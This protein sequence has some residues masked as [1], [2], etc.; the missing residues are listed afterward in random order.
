MSARAFGFAAV[1]P[2]LVTIQR[3][4]S[5]GGGGGLEVGATA[6]PGGGGAG[7]FK[8]TAIVMPS[9][10]TRSIVIGG[11]GGGIPNGDGTNGGNLTVTGLPSCV[12]GGG[13]GAAGDAGKAGGNGGGGG[14]NG[15]VGPINPGG[16]G[17]DFNGQNGSNG[18]SGGSG[19]GTSASIGTGTTS[20]IS[21]TSMVYGQGGINSSPLA[22]PT[23]GGGGYG[24]FDLGL[25]PVGTDLPGAPG[26][27]GNAV[28]SYAGPVRA[29]GGTI[30]SVGG[31]TIHTFTSSGTFAVI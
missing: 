2:L 16:V 22:N 17:I 27:M 11:P 7:Q 3:Q 14:G 1:S 29:T 18:S 19:A 21:G 6:G 30:T 31:N 12:G 20:S 8:T 25:D 23:I 9:G 26:N 15:S 4:A 5:G 24:A 10:D 13:G 28:F